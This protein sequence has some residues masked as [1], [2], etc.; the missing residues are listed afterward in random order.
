MHA[1]VDYLR[2]ARPSPADQDLQSRLLA[3]NDSACFDAMHEVIAERCRKVWDD[4]DLRLENLKG[5]HIGATGPL[6]SAAEHR[7]TE[8]LNADLDNALDALLMEC[9][10]RL[11]WHRGV[12]TS[13]SRLAGNLDTA[14]RAVIWNNTRADLQRE[15][16]RIVWSII[17]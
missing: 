16:P 1:A 7:E 10:D 11:S 17:R 12:M 4:K 14:M 6:F 8:R 9:A 15:C 2:T 13:A 3:L 5:A